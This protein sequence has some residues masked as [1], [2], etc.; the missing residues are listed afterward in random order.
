MMYLGMRKVFM[1]V[2][3]IQGCPYRGAPL[4]TLIESVLGVLNSGK[5]SRYWWQP[6]SGISIIIDAHLE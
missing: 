4:Y 5:V 1:D 6:S 2:S 3:S